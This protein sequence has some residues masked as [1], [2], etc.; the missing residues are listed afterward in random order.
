ALADDAEQRMHREAFVRRE[1]VERGR[2]A[3]VTDDGPRLD[4]RGGRGDLAIGDA[5]QDDIG[6]GARLP[7]PEWAVD[8]GAGRTQCGGERGPHAA[9]ADDGDRGHAGIY[10]QAVHGGLREPRGQSPGAKPPGSDP[11]PTLWCSTR[12]GQWAA[13]SCASWAVSW[14]TRCAA[15]PGISS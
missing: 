8:L 7:A 12:T 11:N 6:S 1:E 4:D 15:S 13:T 2:R 3:H 5:D 14:I 10:C 9:T